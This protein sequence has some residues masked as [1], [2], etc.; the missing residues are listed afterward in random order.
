MKKLLVAAAFA[1]LCSG[2]AAGKQAQP[3]Q[4]NLAGFPP[5]YKQG[6]ADG[7]NSARALLGSTKDATRF[8]SDRQ[9][10]QGWRDGADVCGKRGARLK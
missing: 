4:A 6:Y 10:A 7:C 2:C 5:G 3:V 1:A 8:K 9:Y